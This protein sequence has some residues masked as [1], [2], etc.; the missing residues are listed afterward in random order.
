MKK[1]SSVIIG[2]FLVLLGLILVKTNLK[3][4]WFDFQSAAAMSGAQFVLY[5]G[6]GVKVIYALT[7]LMLKNNVKYGF[8]PVIPPY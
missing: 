4:G 6:T 8:E 2:V 3:A 1:V 5:R 7:R